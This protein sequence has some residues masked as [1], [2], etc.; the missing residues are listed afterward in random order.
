M[1]LDNKENNG[2]KDVQT[3]V[4]RGQQNART[5]R[6]A[7]RIAQHQHWM[8]IMMEGQATPDLSYQKPKI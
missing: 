8:R 7:K 2:S 1:A 5:S 6:R 4:E 3:V